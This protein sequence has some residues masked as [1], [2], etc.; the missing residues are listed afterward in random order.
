MLVCQ[1]FTSAP[2]IGLHAVS[3]MRSPRRIGRPLQPSEMSSRSRSEAV[4]HGPAVE[5]LT[6]MQLVAA[7]A[8]GSG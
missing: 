4:V 8:N 7:A 3:T 5:L 2:A 6:I 1:I